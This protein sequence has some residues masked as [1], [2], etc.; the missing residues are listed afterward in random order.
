[1]FRQLPRNAVT[2]KAAFNWKVHRSRHVGIVIRLRETAARL[3]P[4]L[5]EKLPSEDAAN[6][7]A[8]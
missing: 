6:R 4:Q 8:V 1:M 2:T 3:D 7:S 5:G